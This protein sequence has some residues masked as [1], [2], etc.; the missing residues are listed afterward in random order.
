[1]LLLLLILI[2]L[3]I[4]CLK[5]CVDVVRRE[6]LWVQRH[7][8]SIVSAHFDLV[9]RRD[10]DWFKIRDMSDFYVDKA[11]KQDTEHRKYFKEQHKY[12]ND[13]DLKWVL[14]QYILASDDTYA[15]VQQKNL[16]FEMFEQAR[17][18]AR[19][20]AVREHKRNER[21]DELM[22][23]WELEAWRS[24]QSKR[25]RQESGLVRIITNTC[26]IE[27]GVFGER[28]RGISD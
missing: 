24:R 11:M 4:A 27:Y 14:A 20:M 9:V 25:D 17:D 3:L 26:D 12:L 5:L 13:D 18:N 22:R 23:G 8:T 2:P 15:T 21:P 7:Q 19:Y 28:D 1:M 10:I 6:R 16:D